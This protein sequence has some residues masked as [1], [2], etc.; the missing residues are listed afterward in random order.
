MTGQL[1][2]VGGVIAI[3]ASI[4]GLV[5]ALG[6]TAY[7]SSTIEL[8]SPYYA[9]DGIDGGDGPYDATMTDADGVAY[10]LN[11]PAGSA[12]N[13]RYPMVY[14]AR[15]SSINC[16]SRSSG[17]FPLNPTACPLVNSAYLLASPG[18]NAFA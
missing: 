5:M 12:S 10:I 2:L 8:S 3:F 14:R 18:G 1:L 15:S 13:G 11:V 4:V 17:C 9:I 7:E 6:G 16:A